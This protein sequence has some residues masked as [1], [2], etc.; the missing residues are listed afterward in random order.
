MV[1]AF[2]AWSVWNSAMDHDSFDLRLRDRC[3]DMSPIAPVAALF[4]NGYTVQDDAWVVC[5]RASTRLL[6]LTRC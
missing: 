2:P 5:C 1:P 6:L 4:E 3:H